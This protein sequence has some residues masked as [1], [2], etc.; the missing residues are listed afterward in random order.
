MKA[1]RIW[2]KE[3]SKNIHIP[4]VTVCS[5]LYIL[6][7]LEISWKPVTLRAPILLIVIFISCGLAGILEYL[8]RLN[9]R[10]GAIGV[11]GDN[12]S[13]TSLQSF[14]YRYLPTIIAVSYSMFWSLIDLDA[15]RIEPYFQLSKPEGALAERSLLLHY[16]IDFFAV[17]P[18]RAAKLR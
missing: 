14:T 3:V 15:K 17:V 16:P 13:F 18:F 7:I 9:D 1:R 4:L 11:A 12:G 8:S 6:R 2:P 10:A 5:D